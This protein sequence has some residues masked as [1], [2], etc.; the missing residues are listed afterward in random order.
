M[1]QFAR[2]FALASSPALALGRPRQLRRHLQQ[3]AL[4]EG[5]E[6]RAKATGNTFVRAA[7]E[8][9]VDVKSSIHVGMRGTF[10]DSGIFERARDLGYGLITYDELRT[11]GIDDVIILKPY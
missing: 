5:R 4:L 1:Q 11:R 3:V 10:N 9:L 7:R 2:A 6:G 8:G